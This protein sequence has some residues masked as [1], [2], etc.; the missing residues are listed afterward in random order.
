LSIMRNKKKSI[1]DK[2]EDVKDDINKNIRMPHAR[3]IEVSR[4]NLSRILS[5]F[6][7]VDALSSVVLAIDISLLAVLAANTPSLQIINRFQIITAGVFILIVGVSL[8]HLYKCSFPRLECEEK[9]LI[10]FRE[11]AE[12]EQLEFAKEFFGQTEK[13]YLHDLIKQIWRNSEILKQKFQHLKNA[14]RFLVFSL[15]PWVISLL[16]FASENKQTF[17]SK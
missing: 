13:E 9:S 16:I 4:D 12:L 2:S 1:E 17:L 6:P 3:L 15:V 7:R 11:I 5:I 14:F 10:Y 8:Y